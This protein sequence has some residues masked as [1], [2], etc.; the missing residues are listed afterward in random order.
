MYTLVDFGVHFSGVPT[1]TINLQCKKIRYDRKSVHLSVH[2]LAET[3]AKVYTFP[4]DVCVLNDSI[5]R[6]LDLDWRWEN[7]FWDVSY[8]AEM[9]SYF[10]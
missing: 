3:N 1:G 8:F 5:H 4:G 2:L 10:N 7:N 9:T 6:L